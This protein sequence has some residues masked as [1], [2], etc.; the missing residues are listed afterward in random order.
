MKFYIY[1]PDKN[2]ADVTAKYLS[3]IC[4]SLK[5]RGNVCEETEQLNSLLDGQKIGAVVIYAK[6][7]IEAR[8][9][10]YRPIIYWIQGIVPEESYMRNHSRMRKFVLSMIERKALKSADFVLYVSKKM[11]KH[12]WKKYQFRTD[13][14]YIMPCFSKEFPLVPF[15]NDR[16][17]QNI[18]LYVGRLSV[19]QCFERTVQLYKEIE[20]HIEDT[21]FLV[22][23]PHGKEAEEYLK[24]YRVKNYKV[25]YAAS[26]EVSKAIQYCK[27]GFCLRDENVV[28][29]VATPTKLSDYIGN[30]IM[31]IFTKYIGDFAEISEGNP[32]CLCVETH[33]FWSKLEQLSMD[34]IYEEDLY[35]SFSKIFGDYYSSEYHEEHLIQRLSILQEQFGV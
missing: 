9:K 10:G 28:N 8:K 27:F 3:V 13:A 4:N 23:T 18:F 6:H 35:N 30:G 19:W 14:S 16:Y 15:K 32:Y 11:E 22:L 2:F 17:K 21:K 25:A 24:Q 34:Q 20:K 5:K 7:A 12:F 26:E 33:D 29:Y 31:P 1:N